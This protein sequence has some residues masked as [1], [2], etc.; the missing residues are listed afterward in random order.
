MERHDITPDWTK[1]SGGFGG[2]P[3]ATPEPEVTEEETPK[4]N[5]KVDP[6]EDGA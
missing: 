2:K 6:E 4:G 3:V 1:H 5:K